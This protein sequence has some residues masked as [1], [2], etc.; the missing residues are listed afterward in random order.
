MGPPLLLGMK[1]ARSRSGKGRRD[2]IG[3]CSTPGAEDRLFLP[4]LVPVHPH[5]TVVLAVPRK[6]TEISVQLRIVE[7]IVAVANALHHLLGKRQWILP[8]I[9]FGVVSVD[10]ALP[11]WLVLV[12][13][14]DDDHG[15]VGRIEVED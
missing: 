3:A 7:P 1:T 2:K 9:G 12:V 6:V 11:P 14:P 8:G 5:R 10:A 15:V 13:K 4:L